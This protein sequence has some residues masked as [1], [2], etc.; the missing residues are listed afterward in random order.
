MSSQDEL[1][2]IGFNQDSTCF[3]LSTERIITDQKVE[4]GF[5][6]L[7]TSPLQYCFQ[8]SKKYIV[9]PGSF[10]IVELLYRSN[11][12][13]LVG[14]G[15]SPRYP[16]N[17]VII[18]DDHQM[19]PTGELCFRSEVRSVKLR[20]DRVA[21]ILE[22][23][24]FLYNLQDLKIRDHITTCSNPKGL[25]VLS[26]SPERIVLVCP[27][28]GKG[29]ALVKNYSEEKTLK[30]DAHETSLAC[31]ALNNEGTL[32]ATASDKG[33]L[34]RVFSTEDGSM[35]HEFRRGI[36]RAEIYCLTFSQSSEWL[37]CSSDKGT[38]HIY[39]LGRQDM[40]PKSGLRFMKKVLPKYFDSEWSFAQF[41][42][43]DA[44]TI[45]S[46][47]GDEPMLVVITA[48]GVY[49]QVRFIDGGDRTEIVETVNLLDLEL[50]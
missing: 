17:K 27:D 16:S 6:I 45:C 35:V 14:G 39:S 49:Y 30:I 5:R 15:K 9:F 36:D 37:A 31:L 12:L 11:I 28:Q 25:C 46:F 4:S 29:K 38:V 43:K 20:R 8:R 13:A 44:R 19:R 23:K 41:R 18:W 26:T 21:V 2:Y 48:D 32:L 50:L 3:T 7:K 22:N 47:V 24:I 10:G 34:I 40:N 33:T 42:V 1:I